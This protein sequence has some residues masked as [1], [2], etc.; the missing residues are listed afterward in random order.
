MNAKS[1]SEALGNISE[2]YIEEAF[3]YN[4]SPK[5]SHWLKWGAIAACLCLV[6]ITAIV[7]LT[8]NNPYNGNIGGPHGDIITPEH[9]GDYPYND[10]EVLDFIGMPLDE[11]A[12]D[13]G[14]I[15]FNEITDIEAYRKFN[16]HYYYNTT[17]AYYNTK[18]SVFDLLTYYSSQNGRN[19]INTVIY[20][21]NGS[22]EN[23]I[24]YE[25]F[26]RFK[27]KAPIAAD[28]MQQIIDKNKNASIT[29]HYDESV[30]S[31]AFYLY[32]ESNSTI[33][34]VIG[35]DLTAID[36][37]FE[38]IIS[39]FKS[40]LGTEN[41]TYI[42]NQEV[43]VHYFYQNRLYRDTT[44]EEAYQYYVYFERDG[45][46]YLYHFASNW[47]LINQNTSAI[48]NPPSVLHYV[49]TQDECREMFVDYLLTILKNED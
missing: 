46:Q 11:V 20:K 36:E 26:L 17:D 5:S 10:N 22:I 30:D 23:C 7:F 43:S 35:K 14:V 49:K 28:L 6:I 27:N 16:T 24:H 34:V 44:T 4:K 29:A 32:P 39:I 33:S 40:T 48:H 18:T 19:F 45:L 41:S 42:G 8:L 21:K 25:S 47:A 15:H 12:T 1:F 31:G 3:S 2:K 9:F 37:R 13:L 38:D